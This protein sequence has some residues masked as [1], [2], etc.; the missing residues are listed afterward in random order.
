[1][2]IYEHIATSK[3]FTSGQKAKIAMKLGEADKC[4]LDGADEF[5]Q[6]LDVLS[7]IMHL[8]CVVMDTN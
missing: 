5:L 3:E 7:F 4:L 1:M 6:L 2:Q 8:L